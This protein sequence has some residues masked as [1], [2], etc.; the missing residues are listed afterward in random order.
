MEIHAD[1]S[2]VTTGVQPVLVAN[3]DGKFRD[4]II[5]EGSS[6]VERVEDNRIYIDP[7]VRSNVM[8]RITREPKSGTPI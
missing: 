4:L 1:L 7:Y 5:H 2:R 6:S 3:L 8:I